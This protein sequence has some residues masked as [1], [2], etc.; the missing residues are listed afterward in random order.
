MPVEANGRTHQNCQGVQRKMALKKPR[1]G[2]LLSAFKVKEVLVLSSLTPKAVTEFENA[3]RMAAS[4]ARY[5]GSPYHRSPGSKAGIVAQRVGLTSRC[6]PN[7]TNIEA[8]RVLRLAISEGY[9]SAIWE[10]CF[11]RYVWHKDDDVLYEARLTN[12]GTGEYHGYPLEDRWQW[13]K[14]FQ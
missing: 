7:W 11:P 1:Q 3:I 5:T 8:T 2:Q 12:S 9:V 6:P 10:Q 13:P 4:K 14:N